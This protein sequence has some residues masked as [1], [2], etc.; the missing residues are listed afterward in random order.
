[1]LAV[2]LRW[3]AMTRAYATPPTVPPN[4]VDDPE[5]AW[6]WL[7]LRR[8]RAAEQQARAWLADRLGCAPETL[9]LHRTPHGR[10]CLS[11]PLEHEDTSWS[12]SGEGLLL[13]HARDATV[14]VD[15]EYERP[16]KNALALAQRYFHPAETA[17]LAGQ[18]DDGARQ[19][20]FI[21]LWCAKEAVL[22]A[23]GRGLAFGLDR[24][25]FIER[26]GALQ[27]HACDATLG[28]ASHWRLLELQP[29]VGYRAALAWYPGILPA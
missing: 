11:A 16:R 3:W 7:P 15:L 24:L 9:P 25:Q 23:H 20:A 13:A 10:P 8:D 6:Q 17:W 12:H 4:P 14:G 29:Q 2:T 28:M 19:S 18:A 1:M 21:R 5:P 26:D 27:L 22:K